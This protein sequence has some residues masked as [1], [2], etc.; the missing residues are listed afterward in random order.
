LSLNHFYLSLGY[1][2]FHGIFKA[3]VFM[4]VGSFIR[5]YGS[6]DIRL[7]GGGCVFLYGDVYLLLVCLIN[8][9]GIPATVGYFFKEVL[10]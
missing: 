10:L 1:L 4:C 3:A 2:I 8:L 9:V 6:Q 5:F 7:M